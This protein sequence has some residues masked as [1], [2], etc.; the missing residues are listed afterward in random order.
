MLSVSKLSR[1]ALGRITV[2]F[3]TKSASAL[4]ALLFLTA[5]ASFAASAEVY[6]TNLN[7][8][9][10]LALF[11]TSIPALYYTGAGVD[12]ATFEY[13]G[14]TFSIKQDVLDLQGAGSLTPTYPAIN[15][16]TSR[17]TLV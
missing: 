16:G 6:G 7:A 3:A 9:E 17:G 15:V 10:S 1:Q 4:L 14:N 2:N 8:D 13:I 5:S 11:G 12:T